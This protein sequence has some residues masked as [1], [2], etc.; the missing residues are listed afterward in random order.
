LTFCTREKFALEIKCQDRSVDAT[1]RDA[2][3]FLIVQQG[4]RRR[5]ELQNF[6]ARRDAED[7]ATPLA[8]E[9]GKDGTQFVI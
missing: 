4:G 3:E 8:V 6:R 1:L 5:S 2:I 9:T 7:D